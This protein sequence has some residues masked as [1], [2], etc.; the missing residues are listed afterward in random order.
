[1]TYQ[2]CVDWL[3]KGGFTEQE[4]STS[5]ILPVRFKLGPVKVYPPHLDKSW[6]VVVCGK[7]GEDKDL[8]SAFSSTF[9]FSVVDPPTMEQIAE[10]LSKCLAETNDEKRRMWLF[11]ILAELPVTPPQESSQAP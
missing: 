3:L 10:L 4:F 11:R 2:E 5:E 6:Q 9:G 8:L 1:M 7:S